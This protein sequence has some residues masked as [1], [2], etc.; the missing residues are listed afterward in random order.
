MC[1]LGS[2][3]FVAI[4]QFI[5]QYSLSLCHIFPVNST[6]ML[7]LYQSI[8]DHSYRKKIESLVKPFR[9]AMQ[10]WRQFDILIASKEIYKSSSNGC[11]YILHSVI[12]ISILVSL[13]A[14]HPKISYSEVDEFIQICSY[15][16]SLLA[17]IKCN[18]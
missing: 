4:Q 15:N 5:A 16:H 1:E 8:I 11:W 7:S 13:V 9:N 2:N 12:K 6:G 17:K 14:S 18:S 3:F 10:C